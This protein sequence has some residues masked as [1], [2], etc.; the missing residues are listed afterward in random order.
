MGYPLVPGYESVGRVRAAGAQCSTPVGACVFVGGASCF[1]E[2]RGLFGGAA[3]RLVVPESK[4]LLI[5]D[6]LGP[7]GILLAL[8]ATAIHALHDRTA[9]APPDLIVG[10]GVL[11]RLLARATIAM[12]GEP[13][14]VWE[15]DPQRCDSEHGYPVI[16][17]SPRRAQR[18]SARH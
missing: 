5:E 13:P 1:G 14:V 18:L 6:G 2:I 3:S 7:Q 15:T 17:P 10:H 9:F 4:T 8:A 11:G 16:D 12:G